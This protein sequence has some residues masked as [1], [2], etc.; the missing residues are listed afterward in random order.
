MVTLRLAGAIF[1]ENEYGSV[2]Q[3][4]RWPS[5]RVFTSHFRVISVAA[6]A[7]NKPGFDWTGSASAVE[8]VRAAARAVSQ[9]EN[10]FMLILLGRISC[11]WQCTQT[12]KSNLARPATNSPTTIPATRFHALIL[13][14]CLR[15]SPSS[16]SRIRFRIAILKPAPTSRC[17]NC[18]SVIR[19]SA[20][21]MAFISVRSLLV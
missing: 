21:E 2:T 15:R 18:S 6:V 17:P 13:L 10:I 14:S 11:G 12:P 4:L 20:I 1:T 16:S 9:R 8:N 7:D 3:F 19:N 5:H